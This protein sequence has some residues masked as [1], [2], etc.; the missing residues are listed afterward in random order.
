MSENL[1]YAVY[2]IELAAIEGSDGWF[3]ENGAL[4]F[5]F[6][7]LKQAGKIDE[8]AWLIALFAAE[9]DA[10]WF[11]LGAGLTVSSEYYYFCL[12]VEAAAKVEGGEYV[13]AGY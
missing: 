13:E 11:C 9:Q 5:L 2:R 10:V 4:K 1:S 3:D 12:R 6:N 8:E 7:A